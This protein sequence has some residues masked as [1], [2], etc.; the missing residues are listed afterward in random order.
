MEKY[1]YS[2]GKEDFE[3]A[4]MIRQKV[5][6]EEQGFNNE[7]DEIDKHAYHLVIYLDDHPVAT[8]RMYQQDKQTVIFGRIAV[9]KQYRKLGLGRKVIEGLEK[10]AKELNFKQAHLS[11][12]MQASKFYEKLG[13]CCYGNQYYDEWCLHISMN[14]CL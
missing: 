6:V 11:A 12:Q 9:L 2:Y 8:G 14:K 4:K 7:F 10:K 13:Y 5:F 1:Q 3:D